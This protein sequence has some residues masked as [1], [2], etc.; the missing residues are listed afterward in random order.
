MIAGQTVCNLLAVSPQRPVPADLS[1]K[2]EVNRAEQ[3]VF[4]AGFQGGAIHLV[5]LDSESDWA[6]LL[7]IEWSDC[8]DASV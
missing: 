8:F 7:G 6:D 1:C 4:A 2:S 3:A 5:K